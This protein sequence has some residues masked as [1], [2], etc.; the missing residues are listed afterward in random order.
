MKV[1]DKIGALIDTIA[2]DVL[3]TFHDVSTE[4][5]KKLGIPHA[6]AS[7]VIANFS[8]LNTDRAIHTYNE[9]NASSREA[10]QTLTREPAIARIVVKDNRNVS[11]TFYICRTTPPT[12]FSDFASYRAPL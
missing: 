1:S 10:C 5:K 2:V 7:T 11:R 9:I 12:G 3:K 4:A 8:S 6:P